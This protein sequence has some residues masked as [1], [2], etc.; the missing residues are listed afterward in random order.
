MCSRNTSGTPTTSFNL[1]HGHCVLLPFLPL[2]PNIFLEIKNYVHVV[3]IQQRPVM[4][5][6]FIITPGRIT[7]AFT[8]INMNDRTDAYKERD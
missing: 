3:I 8:E 4:V 6:L 7:D 5:F 2:L 1:M